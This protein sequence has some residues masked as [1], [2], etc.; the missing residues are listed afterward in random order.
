VGDAEAFRGAVHQIDD[1]ETRVAR[2]LREI[3]DA[4]PVTCTNAVQVEGRAGAL[5]QLLVNA[6]GRAWG[7]RYGHQ[8]GLRLEHDRGQP[9]RACRRRQHGA[10]HSDRAQTQHF[11][12]IQ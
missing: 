8:A 1:M 9:D 7:G 3:G 10:A 11:P 4:D 12:A 5:K 2:R 6:P